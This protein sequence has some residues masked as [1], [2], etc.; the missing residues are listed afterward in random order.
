MMSGQFL[1]DEPCR[2][3]RCLIKN[4]VK[5]AKQLTHIFA[6]LNRF[7]LENNFKISFSNM[8]VHKFSKK[9]PENDK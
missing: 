3:V 9:I 4:K 6:H 8:S 5:M 1:T 2:V 7:L